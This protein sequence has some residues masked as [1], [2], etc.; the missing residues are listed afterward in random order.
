VAIIGVSLAGPA[1]GGEAAPAPEGP[2]EERV[3]EPLA[4]DELTPAAV[5]A[6]SKGLE[7]LVKQQARDG[8]FGDGTG[9]GAA[10]GNANAAVVGICGLAF[11]AQGNVPGRGKYA[12]NVEKVI[13]WMLKAGDRTGL[14]HGPNTSH[15]VMY[16]HGFATLFLAEAY[17][18]TRDE[19]IKRKLQNAIRLIAQTQLDSGGWW[20]QPDKAPGRTSDISVTICET[21]ALRAA[22][23][24]GINVPQ[25]T[26]DKAIDC[27]KRAA[28]PDGGFAYQ[29]PD[30]GQAGGGSAFPRSAAGLCILYGLGQHEAKETKAGLKYLAR[31]LPGTPGQEHGGFGGFYFYGNYYGTQAMYQAGGQYWNKWWPAIRQDLIKKQQPNGS[32][33][34]EGGGTYG[35]GMACII[36]CIPYN[37]LPILQR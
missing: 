24:V 3:A 35:T 12:K 28:Q 20:Y 4:G 25:K 29:V 31:A 19:K 34:G 22:R 10:Y 5:T 27:V 37:Y 16:E 13:D 33:T 9:M 36:L 21:M 32:W 15:G 2:P 17:G 11:L 1:W 7:Y 6:I 14:I 8:S 18:M 26:V 23:N 30:K